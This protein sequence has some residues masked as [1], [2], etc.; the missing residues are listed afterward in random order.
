LE[1]SEKRY[2]HPK[3][4]LSKQHKRLHDEPTG[5]WP[6]YKQDIERIIHSKA[7]RRYSD[8]T[9]VIYLVPNDHL[10]RRGLHVQLV[11]AYSRGLAEKLGLHVDLVEAISLGHDVGHPPFGHEGEGYLSEITQGIGMG[12]FSHSSQSCRLLSEI[13]PLNLGFAVYDGFLCHDGGMKSS[14]AF[15]RYNKTWQDHFTE[16]YLRLTDSEIDFAPATLEGCL[17]KMCDSVSYLAKDI[18]DAISLGIIKRSDIVKTALGDTNEEILERSAKDLFETSYAQDFIGFSDEIFDGLKKLRKFN[19]EWIYNY[20]PLKVE[21]KKIQRAYRLLFEHILED[22][23]ASGSD[24]HLWR[25]FLHSK[26]E[27]YLE[28]NSPSQM[29]VDYL[30]GMT[31]RYFVSI[32]ELFTIPQT[33][34]IYTEMASKVDFFARQSPGVERS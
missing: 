7:L 33:I 20:P 8:K 24:S 26:H 29:V 23:D 6:P 34:K 1:E 19:F 25:R 32:L 22:F 2:W 10:T 28:K 3:A 4:A 13:E 15:P 27:E 12:A 31:D 16:K 9:Q 30:A 11:S 21:S 17:V 18:E 5:F 14:R